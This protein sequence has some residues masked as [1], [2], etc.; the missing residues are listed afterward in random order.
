M[1]LW[2]ITNWRNLAL[3]GLSVLVV[4]LA[5]VILVD[6]LPGLLSIQQ[7]KPVGEPVSVLDVVLDHKQMRS[8]D[9]LFDRPLGERHVGEI[10]GRDPVTLSPNLGGT[11][12]WQG[13]NVLRFEPTDHFAMA[14]EYQITVIPQRLVKPGQIFMGKTDFTVRTDQFQVERVDTVEE[15]VLEG[16]HVVTIRG[17]V[18]FNYSVN[19]GVL[20]SKM[21]LIDP[22][23]GETNP[24]PLELETTY[25]S[26]DIGFHSKPVEK[27]KDKRELRLVILSDLK[28]EGG[29]LPLAADWVH[30]IP[31]GSAE[32]L[33]IRGV[34]PLSA[35]PESSVRLRFSSPVSPEIAKQYVKVTPEVQ[36][37]LSAERNELILT[38][39]VHPGEQY[40]LVIA[41]GLPAS[42][43][44]VLPQEYKTHIQMPDLQPSVDFQSQGMFLSASGYR[45]IALKSVNMAQARLTI[46]R[47]YR[48]NLFFLFGDYSY[49]SLYRE[50]QYYDSPISHAFGDRLVNTTLPLG[51]ERNQSMLT[52]LSLDT[53]FR[54]EQ[55]GLYRIGITRSESSSGAARWLLLTDLGIVAKQGADE[56]LVWVSSFADLAPMGGAEVRLISDQNQTMATG[57][58]DAEGMWRV[59]DLAK[60]LEKQK[61]H[62]VT[63]ERGND[64]RFL[65]LHRSGIHTAS[66]DVGGSALSKEGYTAYLY[67]ERDIYRPGETVQGVAVVRDRSLQPP[68]SMP[69]LLRHKDP[70]GRDRGTVKLEMD[71]HGLA[72]FTHVIP[73]YA[74][75]GSHTLELLVAQEVIGQY[76]FQVEEFV[77]DRIKVEVAAKKTAVGPGETLTYDVASAYLFGPPAAGLAVESRVRLVAASFAPKG[78]EGFTF[79]NPERQFKDQ[80]I[81]VDQGVLDAE[82]KRALSVTVPAGL[83]VPSSLEALIAARVQEQGGRGVAALQRVHVHPYPYYL[84]L[85]RLGEGYPEPNQQVTLEYVAVSPEGAEVPAGKLRAEFFRDRWHTVLRRTD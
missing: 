1:K 60:I 57:R 36:Y 52:P 12:R 78:Y 33:E 27:Q 38:G 50:D 28:P 55:P 31:L 40:E 5:G 53:Y 64:F 71:G 75:T 81:L 66:F 45:A 32:K 56:F 14:T 72:Q 44:A 46:D 29:N 62:P 23:Q 18:R 4:V 49:S 54:E 41:Q 11:W 8:L 82:G 79:H 68:P 84:G 61:P 15:Q 69:L 67:G 85:R 73:P 80:K 65:L 21:R 24:I 47:V 9:I 48:N 39:G 63:V 59:H 76:R 22:L 3:V 2:W 6:N 74:R 42:D 13:A 43:E 20:A 16:K 34:S 30:T 26:Q 25:R 7:K 10:L 17:N 77:P 70:E 37:R 19:P 51:G 35:D 83:Q 58:T